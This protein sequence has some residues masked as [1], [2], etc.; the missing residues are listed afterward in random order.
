[1]Y[2]WTSIVLH[3]LLN[4]FH[5]NLV[6]LQVA[7]EPAAEI[8]TAETVPAVPKLKYIQ[9]TWHACAGIGDHIL[10]SLKIKPQL[11]S[12]RMVA[13]N[14][15]SPLRPLNRLNRL[16][17]LP[18]LVS[19]LAV[20]RP[21]LVSPKMWKWALVW[22]LMLIPIHM[23]FSLTKTSNNSFSSLK[24]PMRRRIPMQSSE[25]IQKIHTYTEMT[26]V[27]YLDQSR[28]IEFRLYIIHKISNILEASWRSSQSIPQAVDAAQKAERAPVESPKADPPAPESELQKQL[29]DALAKIKE[30]EIARD[31]TLPLYPTVPPK[32]KVTP[33]KPVVGPPQTAT[34][35]TPAES[36][37]AAD[38]TN[39]EEPIVT[40]TGNK[41]TWFCSDPRCALLT[42]YCIRTE[43]FSKIQWFKPFPISPAPTWFFGDWVYMRLRKH[44]VELHHW[45]SLSR[46]FEDEAETALRKEAL[47]EVSCQGQRPRRL[48]GR[49]RKEGVVGTSP[50][51][52]FGENR[53]R[54]QV[55]QCHENRVPVQSGTCE[56]A[57]VG[58]RERGY[59]GMAH[60][61][62]HGI[63]AWLHKDTR[64][65][66][67]IA[68]F[69]VYFCARNHLPI[70]LS[71]RYTLQYIYIYRPCA[72]MY[73]HFLYRSSIA[74]ALSNHSIARQLIQQICAYCEKFPSVLTRRARPHP[75]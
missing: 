21:R 24:L 16:K 1:M 68:F 6:C 70:L 29:N 75:T 30:L 40:P 39:S 37:G 22:M 61:R 32:P 60:A 62:A 48:G 58:A 41:V 26:K 20:R 14:F 17:R 63:Q 56:R 49:G 15:D 59:W 8:Y 67:M 11:K 38:V 25:T 65:C 42:A 44:L 57:A 55:T 46:R 28:W 47:W 3:V 27:I 73:I 45:G 12:E 18:A 72:C 19:P 69:F 13:V 51:W 50:S 10:E 5:V 54:Q 36:P 53:R 2:Q 34:P 4:M 71:C 43:L 23:V 64:F 9:L 66:Y 35:A 33:V 7:K 74:L 31:K 52:N